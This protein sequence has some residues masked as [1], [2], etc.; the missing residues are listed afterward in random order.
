MLSPPPTLAALSA[1][2]LA[3]AKSSHNVM[4]FFFHLGLIGLF[5]VSI[6]D[7]SFVPLPIPGVTDIMLI[8]YAAGHANPILLVVI[9]TVGSALGGFFS[10]AAGQAGGMKFLEKHVPAYILTRVTKWMEHHAIFSVSLPAILP[11]PLPLSPFVLAAGAVRM[12]RKTFMWAFTISR[13]LRHCI[14]VWLGIHYGHAVLH[15]WA[16][17]SAK[18]ATTILISI[19]SIILISTGIAIWKLYKASRTIGLNPG[20]PSTSESAA[21]Q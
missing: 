3:A 1:F 4:H 12:S 16:S 10:H 6:V 9:A 2:G 21:M 20:K 7:S 18:W 8:L 11:P 14:A 19:W 5:L 15:L 17:F 13:F